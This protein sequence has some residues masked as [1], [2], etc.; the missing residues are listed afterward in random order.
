[1]NY[2]RN[3]KSA[4][5]IEVWKVKTTMY[6]WWLAYSIWNTPGGIRGSWQREIGILYQGKDVGASGIFGMRIENEFLWWDEFLASD[7]L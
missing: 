4:F 5:V 2:L 1:M 3:N 7:T 6:E